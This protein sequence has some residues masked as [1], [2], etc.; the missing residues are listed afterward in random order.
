MGGNLRQHTGFPFLIV[1]HTVLADPVIVI[2]QV[3]VDLAIIVNQVVIHPVVFAYLVLADLVIANPVRSLSST[4][5]P[6][7]W[8][9]SLTR[10]LLT[11][12]LLSTGTYHWT[13][14]CQCGPHF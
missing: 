5:Y 12:S 6:L 2:D 13:G 1:V 14:L 4:R 11:R 7:T 3:F 8:L 10:Y 9:F